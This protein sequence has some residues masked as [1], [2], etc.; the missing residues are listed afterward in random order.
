[1]FAIVEQSVVN[2]SDN[3]IFVGYKELLGYYYTSKQES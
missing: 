3:Q 2:N 1:M